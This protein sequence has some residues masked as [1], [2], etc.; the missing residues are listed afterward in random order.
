MKLELITDK[1]QLEY[2]EDLIENTLL[3]ENHCHAH[4]EMIAV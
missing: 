3:W 2:K 4:F 1:F